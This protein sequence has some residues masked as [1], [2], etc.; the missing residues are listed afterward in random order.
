MNSFERWKVGTI[1][2]LEKDVR[3]DIGPDMG[4][5]NCPMMEKFWGLIKEKP[6]LEEAGV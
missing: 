4:G 1:L 3:A 2:G 5:E 6:V